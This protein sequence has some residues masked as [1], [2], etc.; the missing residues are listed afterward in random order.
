MELLCSRYTVVL[1]T[2][3]L[4]LTLL[5]LAIGGLRQLLLH[6]GCQLMD[7]LFVLPISA[8]LLMLVRWCTGSECRLYWLHC[9]TF[10]GLRIEIGHIVIYYLWLSSDILQFQ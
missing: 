5:L 6:N 2:T 8:E 1:H 4:L 10:K 3:T 7:V 9:F